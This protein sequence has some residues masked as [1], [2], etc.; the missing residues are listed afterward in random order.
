MTFYFKNTAHLGNLCL[1]FHNHILPGIDDG[2]VD[3]E[4]SHKMRIALKHRG[5]DYCVYTPHIYTEIHPNTKQ[6][7]KDS[8]ELLMNNIHYHNEFGDDRYAAEYMLD[9]DFV[10]MVNENQPLLSIKGKHVLIEFTIAQKPIIAKE[11]VYKLLLKGYTP[12]I[13]H[14]ERYMYLQTNQEYAFDYTKLKDMGCEFQLNL[15][16]LNGQ[17]GKSVKDIATKLLKSEMYEYA[18]TD[19][20]NTYQI[21]NIDTLLNSLIW[22]KWCKYPFKNHE[23][24]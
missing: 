13:A 22:K 8:F 6:N 1:D 3:I 9:S 10:E 18:S 4:E 23:L 5:I 19:I 2:A 14:P 17:Y 21:P 7:I 24:I 12:I 20:H 16:S 11:I 15:L